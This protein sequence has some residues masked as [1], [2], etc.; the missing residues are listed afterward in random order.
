MICYPSQRNGRIVFSPKKHKNVY[1]LN[2]NIYIPWVESQLIVIRR[3]LEEP[4]IIWSTSLVLL[5]YMSLSLKSFSIASLLQTCGLVKGLCVSASVLSAVA[6]IAFLLTLFH[7]N[8][9]RNSHTLLVAKLLQKAIQPHELSRNHFQE[10][11]NIN[12]KIHKNVHFGVIYNSKTEEL[13][14]LWSIH[15]VECYMDINQ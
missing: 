3:A 12:V 13:C 4:K 7:N 5:Y 9:F 11:I 8:G 15:S 1:I 2:V 14:K 10:E 6:F